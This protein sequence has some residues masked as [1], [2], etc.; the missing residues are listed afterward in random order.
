LWL[1]QALGNLLDNA[2]DFAPPGSTL[3]LRMTDTS[4]DGKRCACISLTDCGPGI[5]DYARDRIFERFYSLPRPDGAKST[6]LG[7]PFVREVAML[8]GGT[9]TV[10]NHANGGGVCASLHL[11]L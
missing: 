11:P 1:S 2:M 9:V 5:P 7:L 8:H 6:G 3:T 10:A 4:H